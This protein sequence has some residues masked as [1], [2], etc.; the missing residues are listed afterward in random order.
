MM[1]LGNCKKLSEHKQ[2]QSQTHYVSIY[3]DKSQ[4]TYLGTINIIGIVY[5]NPKFPKNVTSWSWMVILIVL[6]L[7]GN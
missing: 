1:S 6:S 2:T 4:L 5:P 7:V 3:I